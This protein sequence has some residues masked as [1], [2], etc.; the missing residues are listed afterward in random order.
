MLYVKGA[1]VSE[2]E[3]IANFQKAMASETE[4]LILED[5]KVKKG[6][7]KF[8]DQ[9]SLGNY[10]IAHDHEKPVGCLLIQYEWSDWRNAFVIWLHSVY[11][12]PLYRGKGVFKLMYDKVLEKVKQDKNF[13]GIRLFVDKSNTKAQKVYKR[14]GMTSEHYELFEWMK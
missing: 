5:E 7:T 3:V 11:V 9:P 6:I 14:M 8:F 2:I 12:I 1:L 4:G 10:L 13:A